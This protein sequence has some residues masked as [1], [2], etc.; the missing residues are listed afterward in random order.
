MEDEHPAVLAEIGHEP[1]DDAA[2]AVT[3]MSFRYPD[4][5]LALERINLH[6]AR[7]ATLAILGPNGGGK[8][9]LLRIF[10]GL[11]EGYTG[12]I[13]LMGLPPRIARAHGDIIGW[14]PQRI[15]FNWD[16]PV[17]V[18]EVAEMGLLGKNGLLAR[19]SAEDRAYVG[20]ILRVLD[21]DA[22]GGRPIGDLSGGQQ[23]RAIIA[24]A[25]VPRPQL[26]MLDEPTV[27]V[28]V[29][30]KR[31]LGQILDGIKQEFGVTLVVV[32]HDLRA[33]ATRS[34]R[35]AC[36]DR[37]LHFHDAPEELTEAVLERMYKCSLEGLIPAA[38]QHEEPSRDAQWDQSRGRGDA[39][40]PGALSQ[41]G[42]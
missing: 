31:R 10:L 24:R 7:G 18:R 23:Q 9:T 14:V 27:G 17:T 4:G 38:C 21:I 3:E 39:P 35:V 32:S 37:V 2:I 34:R 29:E 5:T 15:R 1:I 42:S 26:L 11:L 28:D 40:G 8:T 22:I 12:E 13:R 41:E 19:P 33:A 36:L 6:V 20:K 25:L 30:G 16:F